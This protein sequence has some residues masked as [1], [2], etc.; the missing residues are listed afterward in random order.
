V[1]G[2]ETSPRL[3]LLLFVLTGIAGMHTIGHP[4]DGG[5]HPLGPAHATADIG[6]P[7]PDLVAVGSVEPQADEHDHRMVM[8][9]L[10]VCVAVL[11]GGILVWLS[12][13]VSLL[14][15]GDV[16]GHHIMELRGPTG[17]GPP[18]RI[19]LGLV[20]ADLSVQRT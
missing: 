14:R 1:T 5:P 20:L 3:L 15:R 2:G 18:Y 13:L 16:A 6:T 11:G 4:V 10:N 9:P 12:A 8:D 17:R 7:M 19:Q